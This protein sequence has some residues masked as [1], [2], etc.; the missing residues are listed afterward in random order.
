MSFTLDELNELQ[1]RRV[2]AV[3]E[4]LNAN[5]D[6]FAYS[7]FFPADIGVH[8]LVGLLEMARDRER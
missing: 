7:S 5:W 3:Q 2:S 1:A 4:F 8:G 6:H